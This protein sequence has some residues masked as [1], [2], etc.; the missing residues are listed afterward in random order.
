[1]AKVGRPKQEECKDHKITIRL[2][3]EEYERLV[4]YVQKNETT[5]TQVTQKA[6]NEF[7]DK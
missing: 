7:L 4:L 3:N 1:M 6:I 2:T 5:I